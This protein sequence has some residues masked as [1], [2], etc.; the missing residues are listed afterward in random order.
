GYTGSH[1][2]DFLLTNDSWSQ[3]LDFE[4][5]PG[6]SMYAIDWYDKNQCH[7]PNPEVHDNTL[8]RIF[9]ISYEGDEFVSINLS[10]KTDAEL[11]QY[12]LHPNAWYVRHARLLLPERGGSPEIYAALWEILDNNPDVTR[13]LRALWALHVTGGLTDD[14]LLTLMDHEDEYIRSWAIQLI[15]EDRSIPPSAL[16]KMAGMAANDGSPLVRLYLNSAVQRIEPE[17]RWEIVAGLI[18]HYGDVNDHNLPLMNWYAFEPL[19]DL[20]MERA[21]QMAVDAEQPTILQFTI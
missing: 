14:D 7:S 16:D 21:M 17:S 18:S 9:K 2:P 4:V 15:A 5:G 13:K 8:G 3:W 20:D 6:G 1:G 19:T 10:A 11:V 12:Q